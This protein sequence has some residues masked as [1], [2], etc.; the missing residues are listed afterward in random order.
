MTPLPLDLSDVEIMFGPTA[1]HKDGRRGDI[2]HDI[3]L[4]QML[5][6]IQRWK[7]PRLSTHG[8]GYP[9]TRLPLSLETVRQL[10][11][12]LIERMEQLPQF[13]R[14]ETT[15]DASDRGRL[16]RVQRLNFHRDLRCRVSQSG[17]LT[18]APAVG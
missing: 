5:L 11:T 12:A 10:H 8:V 4:A 1:E 13:L 14:L 2:S 17:F 9:Y 3:V 15:S 7:Q 18:K 6:F 16:E